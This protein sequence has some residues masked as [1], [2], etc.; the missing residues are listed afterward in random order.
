MKTNLISFLSL[1]LV[2]QCIAFAEVQDSAVKAF[3]DKTL[4]ARPIPLDKVRLTGGPL[5]RAQDV[6]AKYLLQLE[7]DRMLA[8]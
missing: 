1:V 7:P 5:R 6:T 4:Q 2:F 3:E 8:G